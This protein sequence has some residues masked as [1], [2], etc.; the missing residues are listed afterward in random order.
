MWNNTCPRCGML[1]LIRQYD[2]IYCL[3]CGNQKIIKQLPV[4]IND[5]TSAKETRINYLSKGSS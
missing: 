2:S 4:R 1:A 3:L 5:I